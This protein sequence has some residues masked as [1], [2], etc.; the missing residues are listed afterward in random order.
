MIWAKVFPF[1]QSSQ[2]VQASS[3]LLSS[4]NLPNASSMPKLPLCK[5]RFNQWLA[6]FGYCTSQRQQMAYLQHSVT[7][8]L[9]LL[10]LLFSAIKKCCC[11]PPC[12][13]SAIHL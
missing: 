3:L 5:Q 13:F 6:M 7:R 2:K 12:P 9:L 10:V 1:T 11:S 4:A 8:I